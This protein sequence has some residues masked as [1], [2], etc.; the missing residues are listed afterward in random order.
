LK[1]QESN[2]QNSLEKRIGQTLFIL[3]LIAT[4][5]PL[6]YFHKLFFPFESEKG[7]FFRLFVLLSA[8]LWL[9]QYTVF[10][11]KNYKLKWIKKAFLLW[12]LVGLFI[13]LKSENISLSFF[14]NFERMGGY[15]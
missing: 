9:L 4:C 5:S 12:L 3:L 10:Q 14:S 2:Q 13:N 11:P 8:F 7:L 1:K 6:S 15:A